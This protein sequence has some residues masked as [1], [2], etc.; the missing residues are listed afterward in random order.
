MFKKLMGIAI[1][2]AIIGLAIFFIATMPQKIEAAA[3]PNHTP[4]LQNG[5]TLFWAGG[6]ASCHAA[7]K[8][9][10][11]DKLV[12]SGGQK[13]ET[14]FGTFVVPNISSNPD[15]GIGAWSNADFVTAMSK[16]VSPAGDHYYPAFPYENY[17]YMPLEDL[18]DLKAYLDTLPAS[19]VASLDHELGFPFNMR[20]GLGL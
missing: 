12:L 17:Q 9:T 20:R 19:D 8:A 10:G 18:I 14:P 7:P 5:E 16:G 3:L 2:A 1:L 13:L 6:C 15:V 11:E 4:D